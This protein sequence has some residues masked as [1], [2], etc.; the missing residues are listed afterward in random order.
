MLLS[1]SFSIAIFLF[2]FVSGTQA[3]SNL[4]NE[5]LNME[6]RRFNAMTQADTNALR[7]MLADDLVYIHSNSLRE[8]KSDHLLAIGSRKLV[9]E[10]L[11]RKEGQVR[12]FGKTAIVNGV[13]NAKGVLNGNPFDIRLIYTA[14]YRLKHGLW[15]LLN[16]QSTKIP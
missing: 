3:Q 15:Q 13:V 16:W 12:I 8:S 10:K 1:K 11:D 7:P 4:A 14:I 5:V 9:Y 2:F 6:S